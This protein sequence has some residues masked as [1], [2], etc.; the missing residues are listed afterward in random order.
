MFVHIIYP[1]AYVELATP[2]LKGI[3][4]SKQ[5]GIYTAGVFHN[6]VI[7]LVGLLM[8]AT[9]PTL[10]TSAFYVKENNGAVV[11]YVDTNSPLKNYLLAGSV[12]KDINNKACL[13]SNTDTF[14][15]CVNHMNKVCSYT[16]YI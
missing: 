8:L 2:E 10:M 11:S 16:S 15:D 9:V 5:L 4:Y 14:H 1:G 7:G 12:I 13:I 3:S 6:L